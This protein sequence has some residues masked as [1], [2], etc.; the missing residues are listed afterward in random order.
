MIPPMASV[1]EAFAPGA[2]TRPIAEA[3]RGRRHR[4][5]SMRLP[6]TFTLPSGARH[7]GVLSDLSVRGAAVIARPGV[8]AGD[9]LTLNIPDL[10][11]IVGRVRRL[12]PGGFGMA[13]SGSKEERLARADALTVFLNRPE[14]ASRAVRFPMAQESVIETMT[15]RVAHCVIL[16][17]S[18]SG[19]SVAT[20][21]FPEIGEKVRIG[22]KAGVVTRHHADGISVT[23]TRPDA[24]APR[25]TAR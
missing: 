11:A 1:I 10:G 20:A 18:R 25:G 22:R 4:R 14:T 23:F 17:V 16:N 13:L 6:I 12:Y 5:V 2:A 15:G 24:G 19:A 7:E 9:V 3:S 21:L 8:L